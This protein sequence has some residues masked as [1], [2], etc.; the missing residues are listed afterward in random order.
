MIALRLKMFW[1]LSLGVL[2]LILSYAFFAQTSIVYRMS[3]DSWIAKSAELTHSISSLEAKYY[4]LSEALTM[5]VA[6]RM[7]F[8]NAEGV[9]YLESASSLSIL[10]HVP[11]T[12]GR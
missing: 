7:G 12:K 6:M 2:V 9:R 1:I 4:A 11:G 10:N 8:V 3:Y 5:P